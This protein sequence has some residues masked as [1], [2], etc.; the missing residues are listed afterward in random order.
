MRQSE[1]HYSGRVALVS[2]GGTGIGRAVALG[3]VKDGARVAITGRTEATLQ[4]TAQLSGGRID[5]VRCDMSDPEAV[6][7]AM[8]EIEQNT[9]PVDILVNAA[10][11]YTQSALATFD[12]EEWRKIMEA[13]LFAPALAIHHVLP[14]M[15]ARDFG[16]IVT[17]GS[18]SAH[19]GGAVTSAYSAS[20]AGV[21]GLTQSVAHEI[22]WQRKGRANVQANVLYPGQTVTGLLGTQTDS[23]ERYQSPEDVYPF[24]R[25]LLDRPRWAGAGHTVYRRKIVARGGWRLRAK[26][27]RANLQQALGV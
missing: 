9:G 3:L 12:M 15:L 25:A 19:A 4:E 16:R 27:W 21:E 8:Q 7:R 24:V 6:T 11:L 20:K 23:P 5:P 10:G 13:N 18:R 14:G 17:L 1:L 26:Q 22:L 2:G